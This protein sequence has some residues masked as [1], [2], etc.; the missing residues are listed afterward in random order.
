M[1]CCQKEKRISEMS[2]T[3]GKKSKQNMLFTLFSPQMASNFGYSSLSSL[4][5]DK[6]TKFECY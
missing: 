5:L 6:S 2:P 4:E 3:L 1:K